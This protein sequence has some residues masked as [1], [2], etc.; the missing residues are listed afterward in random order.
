MGLN[1]LQDL[2]NTFPI[3]KSAPTIGFVLAAA[4]PQMNVKRITCMMLMLDTATILR[5]LIVEKDLV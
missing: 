1:V 2:H 3:H 4:F 5:K